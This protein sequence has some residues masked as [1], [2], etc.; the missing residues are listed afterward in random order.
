MLFQQTCQA[1]CI[2]SSRFDSQPG[3]Q[4][5]MDVPVHTWVCGHTDKV[6]R[7]VVAGKL[8]S[9]SFIYI[10]GIAWAA[11]GGLEPHMSHTEGPSVVPSP[12]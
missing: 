8:L 2:W 7:K 12:C 10:G 9:D 4:G 5:A 3:A 6:L 1:H 11:A